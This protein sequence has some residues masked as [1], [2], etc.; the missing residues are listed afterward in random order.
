MLYAAGIIRTETYIDADVCTEVRNQWAAPTKGAMYDIK[1]PICFVPFTHPDVNKWDQNA[2][3]VH[4]CTLP[5][6]ARGNYVPYASGFCRRAR[7][8]PEVVKLRIKKDIPNAHWG[9][10]CA[11]EVQWP[12]DY[13]AGQTNSDPILTSEHKAPYGI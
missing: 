9:E 5:A 8:D 2:N 7:N 10:K 6:Y 1:R 11:A 3:Y 13:A 4:P 12:H